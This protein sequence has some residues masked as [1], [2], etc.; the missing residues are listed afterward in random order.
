MTPRSQF[1]LLIFV[2]TPVVAEPCFPGNDFLNSPTGQYS[3][4]W[5]EPTDGETHHLFF[6]TRSDPQ[7]R[8]PLLDFGRSVCIYWDPT[9]QHFALTWHVGSNV[10][11]TYIYST[12]DITQR[13]IVNDVLPPSVLGQI[14]GYF[15]IYVVATGW[16]NDGLNISVKGYGRDDGI[17]KVLDTNVVCKL[18][19][20]EW[21]CDA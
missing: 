4:D 3:I 7:S 19:K 8:K 21:Q 10:S 20:T 11:E 13:I 1:A 6:K 2:V 16:S 15:H 18:V 5:Q 17:D 14:G 12:Q 9:E